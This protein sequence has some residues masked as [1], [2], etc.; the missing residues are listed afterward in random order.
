MIFYVTNGI[1]VAQL[2]ERFRR[3]DKLKQ[4]FFYHLY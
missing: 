3:N 2:N 4:A 1:N